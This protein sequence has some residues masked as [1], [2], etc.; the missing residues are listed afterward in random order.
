MK[1]TFQGYCQ[2]C[3]Q[4]RP[5]DKEGVKA[6]ILHL[7]LKAIF[8]CGLWIIMWIFIVI[9]N[10][11]ANYRCRECG[12]KYSTIVQMKNKFQKN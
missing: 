9:M 2:Y 6:D 1:S 7:L 10:E 5:F 4:K 11:L 8:T 12:T 3:T